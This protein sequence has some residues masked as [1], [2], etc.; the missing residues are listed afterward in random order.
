MVKICIVIKFICFVQK[1]NYMYFV[2]FLH[3]T[4]NYMYMYFVFLHQTANYMYFVKY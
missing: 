1:K 2:F 4:A 3:Q